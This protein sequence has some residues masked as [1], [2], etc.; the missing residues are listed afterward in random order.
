MS[1]DKDDND[2]PFGSIWYDTP[3]PKAVREQIE[4]GID[5]MNATEVGEVEMSPD[6]REAMDRLNNT[7]AADVLP[8]EILLGQKERCVLGAADL[9]FEPF[10]KLS[11]MKRD[12]T[13]TEKID[14]TNAQI[15]FGPDG[16]LLVGSRKREIFPEG[17]EGKMKGCDNFGFAGWVYD[18]RDALW[19]YLGEGRHFG[20]WAG[21][22]IQRGYGLPD[23]HF[24]LFNTSRHS[25]NRN[26]IPDHLIAAG[27]ACVPII[28]ARVPFTTD[29]IDNT[30]DALRA[31]G[32]HLN[33][34]AEAE[35][36]V[37]YHHAL[38]DYFKITF[39]YDDVGKGPERQDAG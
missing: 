9:V 28:H 23:K 11:R 12:C 29:I 32:S 22:K 16:E 14:G 34:D 26:P 33:P 3:M 19:E 38:R 15:C 35:G 10:Q 2:F 13:I 27:L 4:A 31:S 39:D 36:I 25:P 24:Y 20:E 18:N 7:L 30:M 37:V 5:D 17:H 6:L 21:G 1:K 8:G